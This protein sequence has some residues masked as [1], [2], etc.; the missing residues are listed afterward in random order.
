VYVPKETGQDDYVI[1]EWQYEW[2]A[3]GKKSHTHTHTHIHTN[4]SLMGSKQNMSML[5]FHTLHT[6]GCGIDIIW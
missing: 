3:W 2:H 6:A 5:E 4:Q 1:F